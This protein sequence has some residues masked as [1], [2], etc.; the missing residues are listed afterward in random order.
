MEALKNEGASA[1]AARPLIGLRSATL[2]VVA[3]MIGAGV[4]SVTGD[5]ARNLPSQPALL[6]CWVVGGLMALCGALSYGELASRYPRSG[7]EY[8]FLSRLYHPALGFASG[9]IS[10]VV[11]F[12]AS[13]AANASV[14]ANYLSVIFPGLPPLWASIGLVSFLTL[15]H[16]L[17]V[18]YAVVVQDAFASLKIALIFL[19]IVAGFLWFD[20][21]AAS[22]AS[23][24]VLPSSS[25]WDLILSGAYAV[26]LIG[27]F[28]AYLGWNASVYLMDEVRDS[29][30]NVPLSLV[31]GTL[32]VTTLYMLLNFV[33]L[34]TVPLD[35][36]TGQDEIG[37]LSAAAIFGKTIGGVLSG[38]I[39]FALVSS[40]SSMIMAGPRVSQTIGQDY[41][42]FKALSRRTEKGGPYIALLFQWAIAVVM[43]ASA[44]FWDILQYIGF[45]LSLFSALVVF[46]VYLSRRKGAPAAGYKTWGYPVTPAIFILLSLWMVVHSLRENPTIA[47]FGLG[48]IVV[49]LGL[50]F[51]SR[52]KGK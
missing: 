24:R 14:F 5:L 4:F 42:L 25:D 41:S 21:A 40:T 13:I 47:F 26:G 17:N 16:A 33:F 19:F 46:G 45:T 3:N 7:G 15:L 1:P 39:A 29:R 34:R 18:R 9:F 30:R 35:A 27:I 8:H 48:T 12:A 51:V 36:L 11:G 38:L 28:Y 6:L 52:D 49:G 23:V 2:I 22:V 44:S 10:L 37:A 20:P 50:Y 43:L 32:I 31:F